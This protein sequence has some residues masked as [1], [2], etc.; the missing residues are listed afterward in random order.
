MTPRASFVR[1][2]LIFPKLKYIVL[3]FIFKKKG[4]KKIT[5]RTEVITFKALIIHRGKVND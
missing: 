4:K 3:S 1:Y 2:I 5:K